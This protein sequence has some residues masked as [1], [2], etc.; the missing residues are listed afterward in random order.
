MAPRV[1]PALLR[2]NGNMWHFGKQRNTGEQGEEWRDGVMDKWRR[3]RRS[4]VDRRGGR[5]GWR[6][7]KVECG[8]L[9]V[10]GGRRR[11]RRWEKRKD[12]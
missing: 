10:E 6:R 1:L 11:R 4:G 3:E 5:R 7:G 12:N 9:K 2:L 8:R